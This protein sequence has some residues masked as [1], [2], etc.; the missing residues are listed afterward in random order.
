MSRGEL[1]MAAKDGMIDEYCL[2][3]WGLSQNT[4]TNYRKTVLV[5]IKAE[6][7][8]FLDRQLSKLEIAQTGN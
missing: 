4:I 5:A 7:E 8:R 2:K 6:Q 1:S 3:N